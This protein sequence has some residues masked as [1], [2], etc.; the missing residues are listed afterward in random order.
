MSNTQR[1]AAIVV[2][3]GTAD[4]ALLAVESLLAQPS[5]RTLQV[6]LVDNAAPGDDAAILR[7]TVRDR[8]WET[9][10]QLHLNA[11]NVGFGRANNRVMELLARA[12]TVPEY[13]LFLNPDAVV[14]ND[15]VARLVA[16]LDKDPG[17][18]FAGPTLRLAGTGA[19][20]QAAFQFPHLGTVWQRALNIP[21][22]YQIAPHWRIGLDCGPLPIVVDWVSGACVL[23]RVSTLAALQGFDARFFLYW[24]EVDLMHRGARAGWRCWHVPNAEALHVEGASTGIASHQAAPHRLPACYYESWRMYFHCNRGR[25]YA[26]AAATLWMVGAWGHIAVSATRGKPATAVPLGLTGDLW[27]YVLRPLLGLPGRQRSMSR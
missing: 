11:Q 26:L 22:L 5:G 4:L 14:R 3:Y 12:E 23:A 13:V 20:R 15:V 2:N 17:A 1:V 10:V 9:R 6:H 25:A 18:A 7:Q 16:V 19:L 27:R 24:E 21:V 8:G